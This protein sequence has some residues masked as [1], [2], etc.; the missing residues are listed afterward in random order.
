VYNSSVSGASGD[1]D[2]LKFFMAGA[3]AFLIVGWA[4]SASEGIRSNNK[5]ITL[6]Y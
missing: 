1:P 6:Y 2:S 5:R 3:E 4:S